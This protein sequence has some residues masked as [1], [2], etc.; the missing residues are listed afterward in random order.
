M[1]NITSLTGSSGFI[2]FSFYHVDLA[3]FVYLGTSSFSSLVILNMKSG[4]NRF[5][6]LV[7]A[8][9]SV[10]DGKAGLFEAVLHLL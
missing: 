6:F 1:H 4:G 2:L 8:W 5:L 9:F 3:D 10:F 7:T